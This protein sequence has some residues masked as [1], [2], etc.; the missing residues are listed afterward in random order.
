MC[1]SLQQQYIQYT[2]IESTESAI[3]T[4]P[5]RLFSV[6]LCIYESAMNRSSRVRI[7]AAAYV[8][9]DRWSAGEAMLWARVNLRE[10]FSSANCPLLAVG[11]CRHVGMSSCRH[12]V[13]S[14]RVHPLS[15]AGTEVAVC[16]RHCC[17]QH[18][19][20]VILLSATS[21]LTRSL[22]PTAPPVERY[23]IVHRITPTR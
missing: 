10:M 8:Q 13:M 23:N 22:L 21:I 4:M 19:F 14:S 3:V 5:P 7:T 18:H 1:A 11:E 9:T 16:L 17:P 6:L 12:A 20:K 2:Y 15:A